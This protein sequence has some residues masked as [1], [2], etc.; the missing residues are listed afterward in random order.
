MTKLDLK[1][2]FNVILVKASDEWITVL[3]TRY[4][5]Y[6]YT[7]IPLGLTNAPSGFQLY[8]NE[9]LK[10]Y[11]DRG[12]VAYIDDI[13]IYSKMEEEV[14]SLTNKVLKKLLDNG[15]WVYAK[16]CVFHAHEVEFVG[17]TIG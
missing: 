17:Y 4:C 5:L 2:I 1:N 13:L 7:V 6:E 9:V 10:Q 12:V 14:V 16:K 11:I 8:V 3:K 15:V